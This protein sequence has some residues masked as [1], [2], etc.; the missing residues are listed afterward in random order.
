MFETIVLGIRSFQV[1]AKIQ[2]LLI[3]TL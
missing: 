2:I 1:K 3:I